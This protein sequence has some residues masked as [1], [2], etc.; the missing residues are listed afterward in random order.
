MANVKALKAKA[1]DKGAPPPAATT[2]QN[3]AAPP[4]ESKEPKGKIE[5]SVPE[6]VVDAFSEEAG[7]RFGF[8]KGAKS[9][10]FLALW[11]DYLSRKSG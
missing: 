5:F 3:L 8:K 6:S 7:R 1:A 11:T 10:F 4:R 9:D 2:T